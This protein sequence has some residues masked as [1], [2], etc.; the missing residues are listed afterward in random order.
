VVGGVTSLRLQDV[1]GFSDYAVAIG[2]V[3]GASGD[4]SLVTAAGVA[5]FAVGLVL[6]GPVGLV[7]I[8]AVDL[9]LA[10]ASVS[11]AHLREHEQDLA[12]SAS[13]FRAEELRFAAPTDYSDTALAAAGALLSGIAFFRAA[14]SLATVTRARPSTVSEALARRA[15]S[16]ATPQAT[17]SDPTATSSRLSSNRGL[18]G[19]LGA[20]I[21]ARATEST[22]VGAAATPSAATPLETSITAP[23]VS[24]AERTAAGAAATPSAATPLETSTQL[25]AISEAERGVQRTGRA[26]TE[27]RPAL[28]PEVVEEELTGATRSTAKRGTTEPT[29]RELHREL[30]QQLRD[31]IQAKLQ[32]IDDEIRTQTR[33]ANDFKRELAQNK[34]KAKNAL[35]AQRVDEMAALRARRTEVE[36]LNEELAL[37]S[38]ELERKRLTKLLDATTADYYEK[39]TAAAARRPSAIAVRG[40]DPSPLFRPPPPTPAVP[41]GVSH[42]PPYAVEHIVPRSEIFLEPGFHTLSWDQQVALFAYQPN[43]IKI[44][45]VANSARGNRA[46]RTLTNTYATT[47]LTDPSALPKLARLE[48]ENLNEIR[49]LIRNPSTLR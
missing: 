37:D 16:P 2:Q 8:G 15:H 22:T 47:F 42:P 9:A 27:S 12:A 10:G 24:E 36:A 33:L 11:L 35:K 43:L 4:E 23:A 25:P 29:Q 28:S 40:G 3:R 20:T 5:L 19:T 41:A 17:V 34:F 38:L 46:Y 1:A 30:R 31:A 44:P 6:T 13:A 7:V 21:E 26:T 18:D 39:L 45:T 14:K 48:Q 49:K 32:N